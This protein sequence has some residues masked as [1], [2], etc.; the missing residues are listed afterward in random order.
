MKK[1]NEMDDDT[2]ITVREVK[3]ILREH[4]ALRKKNWMDNLSEDK[5]MKLQQKLDEVVFCKACNKNIKVSSLTYHN[6]SIK[7]IENHNKM[8]PD[9]KL[10]FID[11]TQKNMCCE[12]CK[13]TFSPSNWEKH[14]KTKLHARNVEIKACREVKASDETK[15]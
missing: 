9:N 13:K 12:I 15:I 8:F 4:N 1:F 2:L 14:L 6:Q 3:K 11:H 10:Q 7:H 5:K